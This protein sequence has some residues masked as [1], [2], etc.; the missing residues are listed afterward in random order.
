MVGLAEL[1][2][3]HTTLQVFWSYSEGDDILVIII[4]LNKG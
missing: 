1:G 3:P 4:H 2:H